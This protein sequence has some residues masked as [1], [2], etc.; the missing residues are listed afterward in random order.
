MKLNK[1]HA[2]ILARGGSKGIKNKNLKYLNGKPLLYW[3]IK[4][5]KH[6]REVINA[7]IIPSGIS[8]PSSSKIAGLVIK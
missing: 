2:V 3:T 5:C 4:A 8:D 1:T 7:S 6:A